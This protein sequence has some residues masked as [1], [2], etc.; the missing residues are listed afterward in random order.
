MQSII[1]IV[2]CLLALVHCCQGFF[3]EK[4]RV[5]WSSFRNVP[6]VQREWRGWKY[7][8]VLYDVIHISSELT[9]SI[10]AMEKPTELWLDLRGTATHPQAALDYILDDLEEEALLLP[11]NR[12]ALIERVLLTDSNFQK[13][14][15]ASD[16]FIE[17]AEIL[18]H[19]EDSKDGFLASSRVGLSLP[20][21]NLMTMPED[22]GIAVPDPMKAMSILGDGRWVVLENQERDVDPDREPLRIDAISSFLDI[23]S[24]TSTGLW[25]CSEGPGGDN[26]ILILKGSFPTSEED[27]IRGGVAV[28]CHS[29]SFFVQLASVLQS[30]RSVGS[31]SSTE[32]GIII[33]GAPDLTSP[34]LPTALILPFDVAIWKAALLLYGQQQFVDIVDS[35]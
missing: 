22:T 15:N 34:A 29:K 28:S 16:P 19:P 35:D 33:Q 32:S 25:D 14:V 18:Y 3:S 24:T 10:P 20:F 21:G 2:V 6:T 27:R 12:D 5:H 4:A 8:T 1:K 13:L 30:F 9:S 26:E 23:A 11:S 17:A 7:S 31:T